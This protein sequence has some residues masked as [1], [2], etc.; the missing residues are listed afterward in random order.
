MSCHPASGFLILS[1]SGCVQIL[2]AQ[3]ACTE[4]LLSDRASTA[5]S[6]LEAANDISQ[7]NTFTTTQWNFL[8]NLMDPLSLL[9]SPAELDIRWCPT[10]FLT[11]NLKWIGFL[12]PLPLCASLTLVGNK[13]IF[14]L[15]FMRF[16][17][18]KHTHSHLEFY[19]PFFFCQM[20]P[21]IHKNLLFSIII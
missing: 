19:F 5:V 8:D 9:I 11:H 12:F 14:L 2:M 1:F 20:Y 10:S 4:E 7:T 18:G 17:L 16:M 13:T 15:R 6:L 21:H 3:K